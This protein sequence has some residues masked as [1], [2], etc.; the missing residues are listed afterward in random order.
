MNVDLERLI[1]LQEAADA[2]RAAEAELE[3]IPRERAG[4]ESRLAEER[5]RLDGAQKDLSECQ[6]A[7][8]KHEGELLD[9]E[10]KRSKYKG[11]LMEVKTNKEYTA[12][13]HEIEGV[14]QRISEMEDRILEEMERSE[15]LTD[16]VEKERVAFA[17]VEK[18]LGAEMA[19]LD[20]RRREMEQRREELQQ[21]RDEV[22][23]TLP[24]AQRELFQRV[25]RLRGEAV[26]R[27]ND[28]MCQLCHV[29]LRPQMFVD[30][31]RNEQIIQC[32][33]CSRILYHEAPSDSSAAS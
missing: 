10:G 22:A 11:Q 19:S 7:R 26:A 17:R 30:V 28:G 32:P 29:V 3:R 2:L 24:D 8:R 15:K 27:A 14:E 21:R 13:L 12:M 18:E 33:S 16:V 25:S 23:Q 31:K 1:R 5:A 20:Q 4:L 6:G 9:L